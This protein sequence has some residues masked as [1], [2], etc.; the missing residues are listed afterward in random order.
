MAALA[1]EAELWEHDGEG[2]WHF[3]TL[4]AELSADIHA[5]TPPRPGF[6]AV[7]VEVVVG[8][9]T[10]STSLFPDAKAGAYVLPMKRAVRERNGLQVGDRVAVTIQLLGEPAG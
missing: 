7:R 6:G 5:Q 8:E 3:V 4:P 9:S 10:W 1:F 2:S